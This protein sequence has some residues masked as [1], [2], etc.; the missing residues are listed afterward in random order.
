MKTRTLTSRISIVVTILSLLVLL[1]TLLTVYGTARHYMNEQAVEK[2]QYELDVIE[3]NLN[4]VRTS[5]ELTAT[6]AAPQVSQCMSDTTAVTA[7]LTDLVKKNPFISCAAVAY[8]P[9]RLPGVTYNMPVVAN[10]GFIS[11]Y[12]GDKERNGD[13]TYS[14]WYIVPERKGMAFW[15]DPYVNILDSPVVS[16]A[17]PLKSEAYGFEGV[18]TLA[19]ELNYMNKLLSSQPEDSTDVKKMDQHILF[20]RNTTFLTTPK[21]E[22]IMNET[23]FTLAE[24]ENDTTYSYIGHQI[25]AGNDGQATMVIDDE[26]SVVSW[27]ILPELHWASMVITPHSKLFAGLNML[28]TIFVIVA[29]VGVVVAVSV[30]IYSV[31]KMLG[32]MKQLKIAAHQLGEGK[33]DTKLPATVTDRKDEIGVLGREFEDMRNAISTTVEQLEQERKNVQESNQMLT[34]LIYNVVRHMQLPINSMI[35]FT[36]GLAALVEDS[37]EAGVIKNEAKGAG[38]TILQQFSQLKEMATLVQTRDES[39]DERVVISSDEFIEDVM[40]GAHQLEERYKLTVNEEYRDR[41]T[42]KICT[43]TLTLET[44]VYQLIIEAAKV[45]QTDMVGLYYTLNMKETAFR[46]MIETKPEHPI[47]V[48]DRE[49]FF[50]R[51]AKQQIDAY[52]KSDFLQLY[53]CYRTAKNLGARLFVD[54]EYEEANLFVIEIP[55]V[56]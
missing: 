14:D 11:N 10:Y 32:P 9:N 19:V 52:A 26:K 34:T 40:K 39:V 44:L 29:L 8:A 46:I 49:D 25:V 1:A 54:S 2:M 55:R 33:Y 18:L 51:F 22:F 50:K 15:T 38:M 23:L 24:S 17:V 21:S 37:E 16:Y 20:D 45:S 56:D 42:V 28:F 35:S 47:P 30:L 31:R 43:N 41:R 36:D 48:E 13:Y 3:L 12:F 6:L 5:I 53:L 7:V 4:K 27:R